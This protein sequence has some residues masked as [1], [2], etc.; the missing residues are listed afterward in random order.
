VIIVVLEFTAFWTSGNLSFNPE[1]NIFH[2]LSGS[3]P[4]ILTVLLSIQALWGLA[5][6]KMACNSKI[7]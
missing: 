1:H 4:V 6:L 3:G 2:E 7:I 5:F